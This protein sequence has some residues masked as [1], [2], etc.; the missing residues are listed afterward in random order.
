VIKKEET[1]MT[2]NLLTGRCGQL[3]YVT[4]DMDRAIEVFGQGGG[5]TQFLRHDGIAFK[6]G[7]GKQACC[8]VAIAITAGMQFEIIQP[9]GGDDQVYSQILDGEGFQLKLHHQC[10]YVETQ[11]QFD[12]AKAAIRE[13]GY[14]I[15][16]E[17]ID[18]AAQY[19]YADMRPVLGH[20]VEY[21]LYDAQVGPA[22]LEAIPVN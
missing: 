19:F 3:G 14:P 5:V 9:T 4:N 11:A 15:V 17:G 2:A 16:I 1:D 13:A 12:A 10:H 18:P 21:V 22:L 20:H 7:P 8:N 6:V